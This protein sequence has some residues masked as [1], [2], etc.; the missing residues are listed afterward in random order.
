MLVQAW[1][2]RMKL[3]GLNAAIMD[4]RAI[5]KDNS[6]SMQEKE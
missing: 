1:S 4:M 5:P 3:G 2:V 6:H